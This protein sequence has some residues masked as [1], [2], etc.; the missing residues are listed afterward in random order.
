MF[1]LKF[2]TPKSVASFVVVVAACLFVFHT[3]E[4]NGIIIMWKNN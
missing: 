3:E 4:F 1:N 2:I